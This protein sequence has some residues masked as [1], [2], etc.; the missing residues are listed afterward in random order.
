MPARSIELLTNRIDLLQKPLT[1]YHKNTTNKHLNKAIAPKNLL[2]LISSTQ[3]M[4]AVKI[5]MNFTENWWDIGKK[6]EYR[7]VEQMRGVSVTDLPLRQT[8]YFGTNADN[9]L[10]ASYNDM[11]TTEFWDVLQTH[12]EEY[13]PITVSKR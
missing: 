8:L 1:N 10:L 3:R 11:I 12:F 2:E 13:I 6:N 9:F 5:I 4:P 7:T